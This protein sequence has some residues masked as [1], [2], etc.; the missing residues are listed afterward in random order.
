[1]QC[2]NLLVTKCRQH[3][4]SRT[5][6]NANG[7]SLSGCPLYAQCMN[8]AF[9]FSNCFDAAYELNKQS[10]VRKKKIDATKRR[11]KKK[12]PIVRRVCCWS[13]RVNSSS[14]S[15]SFTINTSI[16]FSCVHLVLVRH[17]L[18]S[19]RLIL[20]SLTRLYFFL[21]SPT[22]LSGKSPSISTSA[23]TPKKTDESNS[24]FS[25]S[26]FHFFYPLTSSKIPKQL[27]QF[28]LSSTPHYQ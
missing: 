12:Q 15:S 13:S 18:L 16:N 27:L 19:R 28:N 1:M 3:F 20:L 10:G 23:T 2:N 5:S 25:L 8:Q 14:S 26:L 7:Q 22:V 4:Q 11:R 9:F 24:T 21:F 17:R 6:F